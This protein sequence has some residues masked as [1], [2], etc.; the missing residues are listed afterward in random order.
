MMEGERTVGTLKLITIALRRM[1][2]QAGG[3]KLMLEGALLVEV[4]R[5]F[6]GVAAGERMPKVEV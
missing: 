4:A 6:V 5:L 1:R 2:A 3:L